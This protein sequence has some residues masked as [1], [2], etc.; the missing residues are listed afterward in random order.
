MKDAGM[1]G[2]PEKKNILFYAQIVNLP[3]GINQRGRRDNFFES[4]NSCLHYNVFPCESI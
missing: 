2:F 1:S 4:N 3:I